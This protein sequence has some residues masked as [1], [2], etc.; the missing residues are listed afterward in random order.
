MY[1][2]Q[3]IS[4]AHLFTV[5]MDLQ[6]C[7]MQQFLKISMKLLEKSNNML[8]FN[9]RGRLPCTAGWWCFGVNNWL[10]SSIFVF[11][12]CQPR[13]K[14]EWGIEYENVKIWDVFNALITRGRIFYPLLW[15][16]N[17]DHWTDCTASVW[18]AMKWGWGM[19]GT[20]KVINLT[21]HAH[22]TFIGKVFKLITI[23][24]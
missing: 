2:D 9:V 3:S 6:C 16:T 11:F 5:Q 12:P 8:D 4:A 18:G 23:C 15:K 20:F 10:N 7:Q 17:T 24:Q 21:Y 14:G 22:T 13:V 19:C 1:Y